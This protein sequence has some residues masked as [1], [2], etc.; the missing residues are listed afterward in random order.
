[1]PSQSIFRPFGPIQWVLAQL[2]TISWSFLGGLSTEDRCIS[3]AHESLQHL[4]DWQMLSVLDP[5]TENRFFESRKAL[6]AKNEKK[7][8]SILKK[9]ASLPFSIHQH[10]LLCREQE[11]V[12]FCVDYER[13]CTENVCI[14]ISCMPKRF[15]FPMLT[16]LLESKRVSNLLATYTSPERYG[17]VLS[18]DAELWS[19]LPMFGGN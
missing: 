8:K 15:F 13:N 1:M 10:E 16:V 3:A 18:E 6:T 7:L 5:E 17:D 19:P 14:D 4:V 12:Q 2:G 11:I 9:R